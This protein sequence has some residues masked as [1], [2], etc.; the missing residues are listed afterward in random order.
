MEEPGKVPR[1][2]NLVLAFAIVTGIADE[3]IFFGTC[4]C[5]VSKIG[6]LFHIHVVVREVR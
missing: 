6:F 1:R 3:E 4:G 2:L 5:N